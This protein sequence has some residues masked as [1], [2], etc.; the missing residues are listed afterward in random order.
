MPEEMD[1]RD[2]IEKVLGLSMVEAPEKVEVVAEVPDKMAAY[3][4]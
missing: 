1:K 2:F 4:D 3:L